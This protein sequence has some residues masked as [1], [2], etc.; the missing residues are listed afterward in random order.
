MSVRLPSYARVKL[1]IRQRISSGI[2]RAGE[3]LPPLAKL[4]E[5]NAANITSV[6]VYAA[7]EG[8]SGKETDT[9]KGGKIKKLVYTNKGKTCTYTE[10]AGEPYEVK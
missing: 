5:L 6:T 3:M 8:A 10:G 1:L 2:W 9:G 4:A 7:K